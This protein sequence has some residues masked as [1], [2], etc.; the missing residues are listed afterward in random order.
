MSTV[1][2]HL[3]SFEKPSQVPLNRCPVGLSLIV[4]GR[5]MSVVSLGKG[6]ALH[7]DAPI[8]AP[9]KRPDDG[10]TFARARKNNSPAVSMKE[11]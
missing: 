9:I 8:P 3:A 10:R 11:E 6:K 7:S 5:L 2:A 1:V 4:G